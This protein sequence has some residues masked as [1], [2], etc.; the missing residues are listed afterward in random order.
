MVHDGYGKRIDVA[1][2]LVAV[3]RAFI[4]LLHSFDQIHLLQLIDRRRE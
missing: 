2:F 4:A 3:Y 1:A